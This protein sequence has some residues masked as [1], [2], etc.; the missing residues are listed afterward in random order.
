MIHAETLYNSLGAE[1]DFRRLVAEGCEEDLYL[2]FKQKED[3]SN[4]KLTDGDKRTFSRALSGFAN[5]DG[6]VLVFGVATKKVEGIDR[7]TRLKPIN[8]PDEFRSRLLDSI[9][10]A[11]QP[12]VAGVRAATVCAESG[13]GYVK[14][15]IPSSDQPPHRSMRAEREYWRRVTA[16]F[17]RMEHYELADAIGRRLRPVLR[18]YLEL[19]PSEED[20]GCDELHF[21]FLNEGRGVARHAGFVCHIE[22]HEIV[23]ISNGF[24]NVSGINT[25]T[26]VFQYYNAQGVIHANGI[27]GHLGHAVLRRPNTN[28][29]VDLKVDWYAEEMMPREATI[30]IHRDQRLRVE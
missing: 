7:A 9:P 1:V 15:Y 6:G 13:A 16:G 17:V 29:P 24:Q 30:R 23:G 21:E 12:V 20:P 5:A 18:L 10:S 28:I 8:A 2:E 3:R 22:G 25:R 19:K 11:T 27:F 4:G 26:G 14:C